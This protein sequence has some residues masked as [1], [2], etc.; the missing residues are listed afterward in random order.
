MT[1]G[2]LACGGGSAGILECGYMKAIK[3]LGIKY[4][5]LISSSVGTLNSLLIY[6]DD[7]DAMEKMWL[8]VKTKDVYTKTFFMQLL[9][10]HASFY[11]SSPLKKLVKKVISSH[12][13][14]RNDLKWYLNATD[15]VKGE[16]FT[17][18][19]Q[20]VCKDE[21]ALIAQASAS[22]PVLFTPVDYE[23]YLLCDSGVVNNYGVSQALHL[24]CDTI[25]LMLPSLPKI[26][27]IKTI[28]DTLQITLTLSISTYLNRELEDLQ[29][30]NNYIN[31]KIK[32]ITIAPE[33]LLTF[34]LFDFDM[35]G[36]DRKE[37]IEYGYRIAKD[38]LEEGLM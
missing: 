11:D 29:L 7:I 15:L 5:V 20:E 12:T 18:E 14:K 33:N 10:K 16:R 1:I 9:G 34:G 19:V 22:P 6:P 26:E 4:D 21:L 13:Y 35:K 23:D 38:V 27:E 24:G 31:P 2:L 3:D 8:T 32:L 30:L 17:R 37:I 25:I 28:L 36:Y